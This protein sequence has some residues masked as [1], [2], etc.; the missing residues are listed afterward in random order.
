MRILIGVG[1]AL[2]LPIVVLVLLPL[3][4]V[5]SPLMAIMVGALYLISHML[6]AIRLAA[7]SVDVLGISARTAAAM[8]FASAPLSILL[9]FKAGEFVRFYALWKMSSNPLYAII[10]LLID[11]MFDSL[12]LIPILIV[13]MSAGGAP[14]S[15]AVFAILAATIPLTVIVV[16][17]KLLT[18]LQRYVVAS[19]ND[20][21]ALD[22][23]SRVDATRRVV[24]NAAHVARRQA[25]ELCV[26]SFLIWLCEVLVCVI[27]IN[28]A[29]LL[30]D[31]SSLD[32]LETRLVT[33]WWGDGADAFTTT[34]LALTTISLLL[35]WPIMAAI[36][37][38]RYGGEPR[39]KP[40][41][42][43]S[44]ARVVT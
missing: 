5:V 15:L 6:R 33:S 39:R 14:T 18:E 26:I 11:R 19:H 27:L 31:L 24:T 1:Y 4:G 40:V 32:L 10:V 41:L 13:L 21:I 44:N 30:A 22:V 20:P 37:F 9:P 29:E 2:I 34:A 42:E 16:G 23:L 36:F 3:V 17:P 12:F 38:D 8:H 28:S 25:S 43:R 35:P 7:L